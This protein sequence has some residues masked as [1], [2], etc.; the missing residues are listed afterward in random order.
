MTNQL[1]TVPAGL[2]GVAVTDTALGDVRGDEGFYHYRQYS[3]T[4]LARTHTVEDVWHLLFV[5]HLPS[6]DEATAWRA[7]IADARV[8]PAPITDMLPSLVEMGG[9]PITVLRTAMSLYGAHL[10][11]PH[12]W[13][14]P[15]DAQ[16]DAAIRLAAAV[17]TLLAAIWRISRDQ[18]P[19]APRA[20]L[21]HAADYLHMLTGDEPTA[22]NAA[23]IRAYLVSTIDH[24]F[25][26]STFTARVIASA[27]ADVAACI[28][29]AIGTFT[30]P[31]HG[32][33]PGKA[34]AALHAIGT[35]DNAEP[36]VRAEIAAGRRIMGFGHSVYRV[37]DPRSELL[38]DILAGYD[39]DLSRLAVEVEAV[40]NRVMDEE[41]PDRAIRANVEYYAGVVMAHAGI[42][43]E[44]ATP[45]FCV[46]RVIGWAANI[47]EQT[48]GRKIFRPA[49]RYIGTP[50]TP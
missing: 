19:V 38:K 48:Q 43:G 31:L 25:N 8:V 9:E 21:D 46:A 40:V 24:G 33:A 37:V 2:N 1:I 47:L 11:L 45:T 13:E 30:G 28:V 44:M 50:P 7:R 26:A 12:T 17:P 10:N 42:D 4:E 14:C 34:L 20:D 3:A 6:D 5:G 32:G 41:K 29:G 15:R 22:Q 35:A 18:K 16:T 23:A 36:W 49:A 27:G 39:T